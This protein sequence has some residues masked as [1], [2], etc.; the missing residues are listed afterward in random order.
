MPSSRGTYNLVVEREKKDAQIR[1]A[2]E[3]FKAQ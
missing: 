1:Q 2:S 3:I